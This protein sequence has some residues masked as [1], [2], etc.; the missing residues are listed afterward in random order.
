[1]RTQLMADVTGPPPSVSVDP[2]DLG[3]GTDWQVL[4]RY[5]S[6]SAELLRL[7]LLGI[8]GTAFPVIQ[9]SGRDVSDVLNVRDPLVANRLVQSLYLF[10]ASTAAALLHRFASS[11]S[12]A[13]HVS[14]LR[15]RARGGHPATIAK[16]KR[17]RDWRFKA[18]GWLLRISALTLAAGALLLALAFT[19][20]LTG[21]A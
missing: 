6:Y 18:S 10:G 5:Q 9:L 20:L 13:F 21:A 15:L 14:V 19:R 1:M 12:M 3:L 17:R 8:G 4:D 11:D 16:E 2:G 7:A